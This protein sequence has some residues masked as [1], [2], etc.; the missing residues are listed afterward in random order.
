M[1]YLL[2]GNVVFNLMC[3]SL[4][5]YDPGGDGEPPF[6]VVHLIG[7]DEPRCFQGNDADSAWAAFAKMATPLDRI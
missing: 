2:I 4:V 3:V 5:E 7:I 1:S 6:L